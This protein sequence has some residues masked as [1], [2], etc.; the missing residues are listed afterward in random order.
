M[1]NCLPT[2]PST[3]SSR[4]KDIS[5]IE[6]F[7]NQAVRYITV[8]KKRNG[9]EDAKTRLG[10]IPLHK[11]KRDQRLRFLMRILAKEHHFA[12]SNPSHTTR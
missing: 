1:P 6:K 11:R 8:I 12:L 10:H 5:D 3:P 7:Q 4:K 2:R 9:V